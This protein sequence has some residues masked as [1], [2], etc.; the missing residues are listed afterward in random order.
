MASAH[1]RRDSFKKGRI[2]PAAG[3]FLAI[4]ER[5]FKLLSACH[6]ASAWWLSDEPRSVVIET[7]WSGRQRSGQA[8]SLAIMST[9]L[10][11]GNLPFASTRKT[12]RTSS[13]RWARSPRRPDSRQIHRSGSRARGRR[14]RAARRARMRG[15]FL[16]GAPSFTVRLRLSMEIVELL[17]RRCARRQSTSPRGK[18][19]ANGGEFVENQVDAGRPCHLTEEVLEVLRV[20]AKGRLPTYSL[21][22]M[23]WLRKTA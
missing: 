10:Y 13:V 2:E 1:V 23:D 7:R 8:S 16:L 12:S 17:D 4:E 11:V 14:P 21:V 5:V 18:S 9:K 15:P 3:F 22:L 6:W 20:E 19:A